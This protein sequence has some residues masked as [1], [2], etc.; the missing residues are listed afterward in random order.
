MFV[1]LTPHGIIILDY[2]RDKN[3]RL[4]VPPDGQVARVETTSEDLGTRDGV[5][6]T[7]TTF[8]EV[9]GLP[10]PEEGIYLI[11]SR[12][13][14]EAV[15]DARDDVFAPGELVRND[16]GRPIGCRVLSR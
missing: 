14:L 6:V 12:L 4:F 11:V 8:G 3:D 10:D 9:V 1:N 2:G 7:K 13:V 5:P 15:K 16:D